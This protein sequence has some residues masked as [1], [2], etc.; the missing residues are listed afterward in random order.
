MEFRNKNNNNLKKKEVLD[1]I[2]K[3]VDGA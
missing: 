1:F 3:S 2:F